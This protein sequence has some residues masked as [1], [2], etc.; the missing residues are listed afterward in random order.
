MNR[1]MMAC[2]VIVAALLLV[3]LCTLAP[4][5][6]AAEPEQDDAAEASFKKSVHEYQAALARMM[7]RYQRYPSEAVAHNKQGSA[8]LHGTIG[9]DGRLVEAK[10]ERSS[11]HDELDKQAVVIMRKANP[12]VKLPDALVG[13]PFEVHVRV[14]YI[15]DGVHLHDE[16]P[17]PT[18]T[19]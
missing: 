4:A 14:V 5:A 16:E 9:A 2:R 3:T 15:L 17:G 18:H 8:L 1:T 7:R 13:K 10:I 6:R 12:F 19:R 11:G